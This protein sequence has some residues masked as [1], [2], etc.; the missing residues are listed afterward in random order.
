M[1]DPV[2]ICLALPK[3]YDDVVARFQTENPKVE[4]YFGWREPSKH[5]TA[6]SRI[7]WVPGDP[8][9]STGSIQPARN[10]GRNPRPL[11]TLAE[12]FTVHIS[13]RDFDYPEDERKQYRATRLLYDLWYRA[14]HLAAYGT[15]V[16]NSNTWNTDKNERRHGAE[17]VSICAV[18]AM[19]PDTPNALAPD[20]A[21]VEISTSLDD[22]TELSIAS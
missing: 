15:F 7:V 1:A 21:D 22:V 18:E 11:A 17:I 16:V 8:Q 19:I 6:S 9:G 14:V 20:D 5:K 4:Q 3:L 2:E 10:P 13:G 12:L